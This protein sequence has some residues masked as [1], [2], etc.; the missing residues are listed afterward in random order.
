MKQSIYSHRYDNG[1][2]L[3]AEAINSLESAAFT[4]IAPAGCAYDPPGRAGLASL[5]CDLALRGSGDLDNRQFIEMLDNLGVERSEG[6]SDAHTSYSGAML[7]GDLPRALGLYANLLRRAR[8][9]EDEFDA[10][11]QVILQELQSIEDDPHAKTMI[12]LRRRHVP[13]PWGRSSHGTRETVE[14]ATIDDVRANYARLYR[15]NGCI[16]GV[17]GRIEWE[18]L[19]DQVGKLLADWKPLPEIELKAG[20]TGPRVDHVPYE[21]QQTHIGIA[22]DSVPYRDPKYFQAWG[23]V[24]ALSG[25]MS[26]RFFTEVR[27]KRG[28]CYTVYASYNTLRDRGSVVCYAGT[29]A[30][31]AQETLDV[32][33]FELRRLAKGIEAHE[34]DRLKARIKSSLIMQQE[35]SAARSSAIARDWY[36]LE[37][38][39]PLD[40][41]SRLVDELSCESINAYLADSPPDN[42]T[43]LT[44]GPEPL[45]VAN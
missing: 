26:S 15:P 10:C 42:F 35:S 7:A 1:L 18:P 6:V 4:F 30:D 21:G 28:L 14:A 27:E 44:L 39:R 40:E 13:P 16:L 25:G 31:R 38:V 12:E 9:P 36:H 2:V 23:A 8:L 43:V 45:K 3:V 20:Q 22:Y 33:L 24:G 5:T 29:S 41:V 11:Q 32:M 17:A 37:R 19:R 34:I